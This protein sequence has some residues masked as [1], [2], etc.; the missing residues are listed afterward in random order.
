MELNIWIQASILLRLSK[1]I[2]RQWYSKKYVNIL[3]T[4][5]WLVRAV[6]DAY[7]L[8]FYFLKYH[9]RTVL[10][11]V[12]SRCNFYKFKYFWHTLKKVI[13]TY[14]T[15]ISRYITNEVCDSST[16]RLNTLFNILF[17]CNVL[18]EIWMVIVLNV[19]CTFWYNQIQRCIT[20]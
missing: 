11:M 13:N 6:V 14:V 19:Y 2:K 7:S 3:Q 17:T 5:I 8:P 4:R 16:R 12:L 1:L 20:N 9:P 15:Y 10:L 18:S